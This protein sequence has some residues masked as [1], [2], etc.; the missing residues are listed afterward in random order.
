[1]KRGRPLPIFRHTIPR[2]PEGNDGGFATLASMKRIKGVVREK[3]PFDS[4]KNPI[5]QI[6]NDN[7]V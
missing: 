4:F 5:R 1:M 6:I 3:T 7:K 2:K